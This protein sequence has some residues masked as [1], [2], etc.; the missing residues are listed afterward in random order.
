LKQGNTTLAEAW[1]A[2][3]GA[4][5]NHFFL[6]SITEWLYHDLAG[7]QPDEKAP[8]FKHINIRPR[9]IT[10]L[11]W[12]EAWHDTPH[13]RVAVRW[14]KQN[15]KLSLRISIPPNTTATIRMPLKD[16]SEVL[17]EVKSGEHFFESDW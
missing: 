10:G 3:L 4:S 15:D 16:G 13:G 9:P 5:Q 6:G 11:D 14:E 8:G 7:I 17:H 1:N 12:V 2:Q